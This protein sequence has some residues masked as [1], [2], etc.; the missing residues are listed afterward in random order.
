MSMLNLGK[1]LSFATKDKKIDM[2]AVINE[3]SEYPLLSF[4][5]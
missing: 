2:E 5:Q 1:L 3:L 4:A